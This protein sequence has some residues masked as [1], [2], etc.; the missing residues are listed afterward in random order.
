[1]SNAIFTSLASNVKDVLTASAEEIQKGISGEIGQ[2][3]TLLLILAVILMG[4]RILLA[5]YTNQK[6]MMIWILRLVLVWYLI[7]NSDAY[8][9]YVRD[10]YDSI[11][12]FIVNLFSSDDSKTHRESVY[13]KL[14][15][16]ILSVS[17][18]TEK[19][20]DEKN[21]SIWD[22]EFTSLLASAAL[23]L[24]SWL[25]S[26]I[27]FAFV[28]GIDLIK[29]IFLII[30]PIFIAMYLFE[31]TR[32]YTRSWIQAMIAILILLLVVL[33]SVTIYNTVMG[34]LLKDA[35]ETVPQKC[36]EILISRKDG[37]GIHN[38]TSL[39]RPERIK[40]IWDNIIGIII[41][42]LVSIL[43]LIASPIVANM[44][45]GGIGAPVGAIAGTITSPI[46]RGAKAI[47]AAT[48]SAAFV[49]L[50][51]RRDKT[52]PKDGL[53]QKLINRG[54]RLAEPTVDSS[55]DNNNSGTGTHSPSRGLDRARSENVQATSSPS[56]GK[57]QKTERTNTQN[58]DN[59]VKKRDSGHR[60]TESHSSST[61]TKSEQ[62]SATAA[63]NNTQHAQTNKVI[64]TDH[65]STDN[66]T[67]REQTSNLQRSRGGTEQSSRP[68]RTLQ[69][70]STSSSS[71]QTITAT[72]AKDNTQPPQTNRVNTD[73]S[74]TDNPRIRE[75]AS[76][77]Q[78]SKDETVQ[79]SRPHRTLQTSST[80]NSNATDDVHRKTPVKSSVS[81]TNKTTGKTDKTNKRRKI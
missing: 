30:G 26:S 51:G 2:I 16:I 21:G 31:P 69:T 25:V 52:S 42:N 73:Y 79:S 72:D 38:T 17:D 77:L 11:E 1:M 37:D 50:F 80:S 56:R 14:D 12:N 36:T 20:T 67:T 40:L 7:M 70:S 39:C 66:P 35:F 41:W 19:M 9:T 33:V 63:K 81:S 3:L 71:G 58:K 29:N 44:L 18:I 64:N 28:L 61:S 32:S 34:G 6:E 76:N 23:I 13:G 43:M 68:R 62:T 74:S 27:A 57:G 60:T 24:L 48:A 78:R 10:L 22:L 54:K 59:D 46:N 75:Q 4:Y 47:T 55:T 65:S 5:T 8:M 45:S 49:G 53:V 15:R